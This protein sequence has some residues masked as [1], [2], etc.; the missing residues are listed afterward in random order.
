VANRIGAQHTIFIGAIACLLGGVWF[1]VRR[2]SLAEYVR[3]IYVERGILAWTTG[4]SS[5]WMR[6]GS[7]EAAYVTLPVR[8]MTTSII[9][10]RSSLSISIGR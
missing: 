8:P 4:R 1:A 10:N 6:G 9:S 3:P 5:R 7:G 2:K